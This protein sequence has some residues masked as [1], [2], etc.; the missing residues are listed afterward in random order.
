MKNRN[1][2]A[3][4]QYYWENPNYMSVN[5][6]SRISTTQHINLS[7]LTKDEVFSFNSNSQH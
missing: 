6:I 7:R 2:Q 4:H 1:G 5:G 3:N